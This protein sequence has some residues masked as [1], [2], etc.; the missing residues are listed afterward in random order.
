MKECIR[1]IQ[2]SI[3]SKMEK[4]KTGI[5]AKFKKG[6]KKT[7]GRIASLFTG[8]NIDDALW[9]DIYENLV[10]AD[11][12]SGVAQELINKVKKERSNLKNP[13]TLALALKK[14]AA[15]LF[16]VLADNKL[17]KP[18]VILVIGVN[19]AGKTT[20]IAKMTKK[21]KDAGK[22]VYLCAA[23]T[24]RAAAIDQLREW[25]DRL[26]VPIFTPMEGADPA[27]T[28]YEG[29]TKGKAAGADVIIVDTA[30]RLHT[31]HNLMEEL[32]KVER[33]IKKA[34]DPSPDE[35]LLV[36]DGTSGQNALN[37]AKAFSSAIS[38]T[39]VV[40][41]KLD[42]TAKGGIVLRIASEL[43][44]AVKYVGLG[45]KAEDLVDFVPEAYVEGIF[46]E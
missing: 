7:S 27:A 13:Q 46:D 16:P 15:A 32:K 5:F 19:G 45:E 12:G 8:N 3:R 6:F 17:N 29:V 4:E 44:L 1:I 34:N 9:D 43:K 36:L 11:V 20:T 41:T 23:D 26:N 25:A 40:I 18:H 33:V 39:S 28:A 22:K 24:F 42:G 38:V 14:E 35:V 31:K 2:L 21:Y 10:L 37:Q 30:G